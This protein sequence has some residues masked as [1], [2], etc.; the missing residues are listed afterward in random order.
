[1]SHRLRYLRL[2]DRAAWRR[3][4]EQH[5]AR[6]AQAWLA[7]YRKGCRPG[8]LSYEETLEEA[9]CFGWIDGLLRRLDAKRFVLRFTPRR[10]GS[11]WS[12]S[13]KRR[14]RRL[15]REGRMTPHGLARIAE[16]KTNGEWEAASRREDVATLPTDLARALRRAGALAAFRR[17]P[18]SRRKQLLWWISS[19]R[20]P[21]TRAR[22]IRSSAA[23]S[24]G[25][26][27]PGGA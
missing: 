20:R 24:G 2:S 10:R 1:M 25:I 4:L 18:P 19:A 22:R 21:E 3:W 14:V 27:Q 8:A 7:L 26:K 13:N 15:I 9:L 23:L 17:L 5:H 11:I 12:E 6:A 16:A